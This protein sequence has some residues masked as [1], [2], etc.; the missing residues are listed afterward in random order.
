VVLYVGTLDAPRKHVPLL[1]QAAAAALPQVPDLEVWLAGEGDPSPLLRDAPPA[2][3]DRVRH[4]G[5][6]EGPAL[7]A[8]YQ[9]AWCL[10]LLSEREVFGMA[11]L[12]GLACGLPALVLDDGWGP[13]G[14]VADGC[15]VATAAD[16]AGAALLQVLDLA[17]QPGT[18]ERCR[19]RAEDYDWKR[20]VAPRVL[21]VYG[22]G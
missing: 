7:L 13:A 1:L 10:A 3:R 15:G 20:A 17:G 12:E 9:Q 21:E 16:E 4:L 8:A 2:V 14:L 19:A 11:V 18:R 6:L 5:A 22:R